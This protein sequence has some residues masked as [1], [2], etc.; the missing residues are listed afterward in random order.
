MRESIR[1]A[2]VVGSGPIKI[3]EAAEFDYSGSQALKALKE[4]GIQTILVN[5]NV[6]TVQ[7]S[8]KFADKLYML[9]TVWWTVEKVIERERPDAILIGFG[10][11]SALNVGV[12]LHKKGI[13]QKYGVKVLGTPIE[14]IE[15]AL[16]REKFRETMIENNLPVPPSLSARSEE[17]AIKNARIVG[18]PVMVR[19]SFNLGGRGSLVA[20]S[21]E[22]LKKNIRRALSQSYIGE[23]L[24]EK[25]LHH[26][27]ELEYEVMRDKKGNSA[28]IACIENLDPMGVHTGESTVVAPCQTLDNLEYQNMRKLSIEVAKSIDLVGECNVQFALNPKAYEYYI[29]ET[30]PR[31]SRSSA[32]ASKATGYPLAYVSA[33]LALGYELYEVINKVSG[34][35]CAC[36]EPSLDY[37][38]IKI[39]RWDLDKFENVDQSLGTEMMSVG[40]VMSIGRSFEES[41]QK[42][43]R[44]LDLG[45]PGVVGGKVYNSKITKE[46]ALKNLKDRR[47]YWFLYAA[48]AFKE[49]ATIEEV[50]EATGINKFFLNKIKNLV[51][52][53]ES[54]KKE[55]KINN[56]TIKFAKKLGFNDEQLAL[57]LRLPV[58]EI[59]KLREEHKIFPVVK[60]IDTLAGEWPA[61]TNYMYLTYNGLQDDIEFSSGNK[62]LI[63]G[64]GGFRIGVSV[65]FDWSVVSLLDAAQ[66][67]FDEVAV[68]NFNPE[69][70][71][72]DWD[73][74]RKLYFDEISVE[75]ILDLIRKENF[76][77]VATFSGG[78]IGNN[79]AKGLEEKGIKLLGTSGSSVDMAENRE[80]FSKLLDKLNIPQPQWISASSLNEIKKFINEVGFPVLVRPS[81][82]LSGSSMKIAYNEDELY[83]YIRKA[84]EISPKHPVVISRY[85]EDAIEAEIDA[86]SDGKKVL[87]ILMEHVEEAG[88]HSGD[89]TMSI[90]H[91]KL[92]DQSVAMMREYVIRLANEINIKGPFNTQFV[93]K[94]NIPHIIELNLRASRSM[95]FS[96]KAK[97]INIISASM[98]AIFEGF[99]FNEEY[100]EPESKYWAVKSP[101]FSWAQLRGAYP[102][103]GPEMKSTGEAAAF[104]VTFYDALLKSW[105]SSL[106][107]KIP[108]K[109][110]V[111]L[112]YGERNI[113]Y[114]E[115]AI[116]NLN[117][118]GLIVY[119]LSEVEVKGAIPIDKQKAEELVRSK[120]VQLI[121]T[122]GYLKKIDYS[123]RRSAV[124]Y[125]IPI[126]LNGR[127]GEELSK[128]FLVSD[129]LTY[130]EVSEYG[131][132]I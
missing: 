28:V 5:S 92:S 33:K 35:T 61:V 36:F 72:T 43:I 122:D 8:K 40:E 57:A 37:I 112:V 34:R 22:D 104:G 132:G 29:I 66:R 114:L 107:N 10:G 85:I 24:I 76:R 4:E 108:S 14:G 127:L 3:A 30:N 31:M 49:G 83:E 86:A 131:G 68:L 21:E 118:Y 38:V 67:Y 53:Y 39:P 11:Q 44:M 58:E 64:A 55:G 123:I 2:L 27:I 1:K 90:P 48:K 89:A 109:D 126:I 105:L 121:I 75:R 13:L 125:N 51:E 111:S 100:Y 23:V 47:P 63:V 56:E 69:T 101:Q 82:V 117:K 16:S 91:R 124:D 42:A 65:E 95:P 119:T 50:Y 7:T 84:T 110:G 25:Y 120:K 113:Q 52:F 18:Y 99:D 41:L 96:S 59:R 32:L 17:E 60:Q 87:G 20:W 26:W 116:K 6:A 45:E 115:N 54:L 97:G 102:F 46:E 88:V 71:S 62:L 19:V 103:L 128:A 73:I 129:S 78:Q 106:P 74:T 70:V 93:V 130:Y 94:N 98:K 15:K 79:I 80:K 81:Y 77:Y 12:D 9:P